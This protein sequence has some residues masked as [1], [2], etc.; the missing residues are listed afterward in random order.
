MGTHASKAG[1][2][3]S[4]RANNNL[5]VGSGRLRNGE[6]AF[7][8]FAPT[9]LNPNGEAII[10]KTSDGG[11]RYMG[12]IPD[13]DNIRIDSDSSDY[14]QAQRDFNVKAS[15]SEDGRITVQKAGLYDRKKTF[16]DAETFRKDVIKRIDSRSQ[17]DK[18]ELDSLKKGRISQIQAE[19][20]RGIVKN[21]TSSMAIKKM[22]EGIRN[23]MQA[24]KARL[25]VA[26]KAKSKANQVA[27]SLKRQYQI[28]H[29]L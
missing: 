24:V 3:G 29:G 15:M 7:V 11:Y 18:D 26:G 28:R 22:N 13:Y 6:S 14:K 21:N 2:I 19:Y 1:A 23:D 20:Y 10:A 9:G 25:E 17:Y 16:K 5:S 12:N 8:S 27:D 4:S